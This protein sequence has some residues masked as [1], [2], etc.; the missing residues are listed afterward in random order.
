[1]CGLID[2]CACGHEPLPIPFDLE[3]GTRLLTETAALGSG[4]AHYY[5]S[6][7][8][9]MHGGDGRDMTYDVYLMLRAQELGDSDASLFLKGAQQG[10]SMNKADTRHEADHALGR[11]LESNDLD[12]LR[13]AIE[14]HQRTASEDIL[15]EARRVRDKWKKRARKKK[16]VADRDGGGAAA[17]QADAGTLREIAPRSS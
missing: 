17:G 12:Q 7:R 14:E 8:E 4:R 3:Q 1:M 16:A 9:A 6:R 2:R 15:G 10:L 11:A 13:R 5:L